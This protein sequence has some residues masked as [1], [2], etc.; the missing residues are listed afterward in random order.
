[1]KT[2]E[3]KEMINLLQSNLE[4]IQ[5]IEEQHKEIQRLESENK[6]LRNMCKDYICENKSYRSSMESENKK[7]RDSIQTMKNKLNHLESE[8]RTYKNTNVRL[9]G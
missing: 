8:L 3:M 7:L 2:T 5:F 1:M 9:W 4:K 6:T